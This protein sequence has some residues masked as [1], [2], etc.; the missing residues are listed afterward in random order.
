MCILIYYLFKINYIISKYEY[1]TYLKEMH[2]TYTNTQLL[3]EKEFETPP[4]LNNDVRKEIFTLLKFYLLNFK[5]LKAMQTRPFLLHYM[6]T[7]N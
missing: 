2:V 1:F 5:D 6:A 7:S 4:I 3:T